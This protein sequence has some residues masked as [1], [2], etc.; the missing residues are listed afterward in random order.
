MRRRSFVVLVGI[1]LFLG[2]CDRR[3]EGSPLPPDIG[4]RELPA[5]EGVSMAYV[6]RAQEALR[7]RREEEARLWLES[8][9]AADAQNPYAYHLLGLLAYDADD[10]P[11]AE[12]LFQKAHEGYKDGG[13]WKVECDLLLGVSAERRKHWFVAKRAFE[14]VLTHIPDHPRA[15]RGYANALQHLA[16]ERD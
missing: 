9:I 3:R 6:R 15:R 10:F 4:R 11:Q 1:G 16:R 8:A 13:N 7:A 5:V 2:G 14:S 12:A